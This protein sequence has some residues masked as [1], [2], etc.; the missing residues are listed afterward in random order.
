M[1]RKNPVAVPVSAPRSVKSRTALNGRTF[2]ISSSISS[3]GTGVYTV[4]SEKPLALSFRMAS[5]VV[6]T[7]A[8]TP[9]TLAVAMLVL[10]SV[11][12]LEGMSQRLLHLDDGEGGHD[13]DEAEEEEEEP[14]EGAH[15]DGR[16]RDGRVVRT[17]RVGVEVEAQP[18]HDDVE[19]LEPHP[20]ENEDRDEVEPGRVEADLLREEDEGGDAVAEVH[21]PVRPRVLL[22]GLGEHAGPLEVVAA[23][24]GGEDLADIEV[25]QDQAGHEDELGHGVQVLVGDVLV[26][27]EDVAHGQDEDEHHGE[28]GEDGPV[29]EE[30]SE[31]GRVPD[32][33]E[34]HGEVEGHHAV[35]GEHEGGGE[36]GEQGV[37]PAVV[38]AST[39]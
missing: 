6:S 30:G 5:R 3:T 18:G 9:S 14:G 8:K 36:G 10:G 29:H 12:V 16:V 11:R 32:R 27:V 20:D 31:E 26:P 33:H 22:G 1:V 35:H 13:P 24:P 15:D 25:A 7:W 4:S 23:V 39:T 17:P 34:G 28:A 2:S 38:G 37:G 21:A 19:A